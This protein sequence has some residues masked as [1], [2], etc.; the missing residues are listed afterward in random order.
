MKLTTQ[1]LKKLIRE[2]LNEMREPSEY[3]AYGTDEEYAREGMEVFDYK[4][5][6]FAIKHDKQSRSTEL[7]YLDPLTGIPSYVDKMVS[8]KF[9]LPDK[10][11]FYTM[12]DN[13][14]QKG[15]F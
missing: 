13:K 4:G 6:K 5:Y 9:P 14:I 1:R 8:S 12:L 10:E 3:D 15:H 2:A 7:F 11:D